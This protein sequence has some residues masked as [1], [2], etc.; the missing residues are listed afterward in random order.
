LQPIFVSNYRVKNKN[1]ALLERMKTLK[2]KYKNST[3]D[4]LVSNSPGS[5][6]KFKT[7]PNNL[8][9]TVHHFSKGTVFF[10]FDRYYPFTK[11]S[12]NYYFNLLV[13]GSFVFT[14]F[15]SQKPGIFLSD[16]YF[17]LYKLITDFTYFLTIK[18]NKLQTISL[19]IK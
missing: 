17:S 4:I 3:D 16:T 7:Y 13:H 19:I 1:K 9:K 15:I 2:N 18:I 8:I 6:K 5:G 10:C 14:Y 11:C 12:L